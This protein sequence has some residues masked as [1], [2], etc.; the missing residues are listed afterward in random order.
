[1]MI[2]ACGANKVG[3]QALLFLAVYSYGDDVNKAIPP[4]VTLNV[5]GSEDRRA[6]FF[7]PVLT[8]AVPN[9]EITS[10]HNNTYT[11]ITITNVTTMVLP[12]SPY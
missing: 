8:I 3:Q 12:L 6:Q 2:P 5:C 7:V 9:T 10:I 4:V 1:M 11:P